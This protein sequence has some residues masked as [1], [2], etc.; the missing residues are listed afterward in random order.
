MLIA[1]VFKTKDVFECAQFYS[2]LLNKK[3]TITLENDFKFSFYFTPNNFYHLIGL[4]KLGNISAFKGK[5]SGLIFKKILQK[6][7]SPQI[8]KNHKK[9]GMIANRIKYFE[10]IGDLLDKEQ[11][12]VIIN[13]DCNLVPT[14]KLFNTVFIFFA[15]EE[16][17]YTH[18]TIGKDGIKYYP[19]TF[20]YENS[21]RYVNKQDLLDITNI[22]IENV[23][24]SGQ[25]KAAT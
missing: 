6:E 22:K 14:T 21:Q 7:I 3:Y 2:T 19:E 10:R 8:I 13:F 11:S 12:K 25:K 17:G 15:H 24:K 1:E 20:I 4:E 9:Y 5:S 23:R 16:S 18:L